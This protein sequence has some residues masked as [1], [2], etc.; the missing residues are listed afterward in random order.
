MKLFG[1]DVIPAGMRKAG[2]LKLRWAT[3]FMHRPWCMWRASAHAQGKA[4]CKAC[5]SRGRTE[6]D[7]AVWARHELLGA[8]KLVSQHQELVQR[9]AAVLVVNL[10]HL[11]YDFKGFSSR[12]HAFAP[13][14]GSSL[15]AAFEATLGVDV[16]L[17]NQIKTG[18]RFR[19]PRAPH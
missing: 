13:C 5:F 16:F 10:A 3:L 15:D 9:G 18:G 19:P 6:E 17:S 7:I 1:K 12:L 11:L 14:L 2:V 8:E 4:G